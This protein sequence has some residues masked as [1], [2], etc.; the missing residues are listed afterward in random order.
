MKI[1]MIGDKSVGKTTFMMSTYGLMQGENVTGFT[2]R[3]TDESA[4]GRLIRAYEDFRAMGEYPPPTV[5]MSEYWYDFYSGKDW[6]MKYSLVDNVTD[7]L[8]QLK[9]SQAMMLFL[10]GYDILNG[11]DED[12]T[13][14]ID[15]IYTLMNNSFINAQT[16]KLIMVIFSQC[17]RIPDFSDEVLNRLMAPV[18]ELKTMADKSENVSF[19][20]VPTACALDCMMDL[21]YTMATLM[22]FGYLTDLVERKRRLDTTLEAIEKQYGKG[23]RRAIL[24]LFDL[25]SERNKA[26]ARYQEIEG[27][28]KEFNAMIPKFE[29]LKN[30]VD[31]YKLGTSYRIKSRYSSKASTEDPF[32][33]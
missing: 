24:D 9:D 17:D 7:L 14:Q 20:A 18:E 26:R 12:I 3:C 31:D 4:H 27:Q 33:I 19:L 5:R 1:T 11:N 2:L 28:I 13:E 10:N 30:Y 32:S 21:D 22:Y 23:I 6:I 16:P 25:D 15:D 29:K 8:R